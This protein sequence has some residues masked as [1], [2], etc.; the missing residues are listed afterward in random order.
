MSHLDEHRLIEKIQK[1]YSSKNRVAGISY[2]EKID[3]I[4]MDD[5]FQDY[6][7]RKDLNIICFNNNQLI[8][9]GMI[10]PAGPLREGLSSLKRA[11]IIIINGT[12]NKDFEEKVLRINKKIEIFYSEYKPESIEHLLNK[13]LIAISGI[14]N[15]QNFFQLLKN[16][17][18]KVSKKLV[19]PDHYI[20]SK[21]EL[22]SIVADAEKKN[23]DIIMSEKDYYKIKNFESKKINCLKVS[24]IINEQEKL[25]NKINEL[26]Y[27]NN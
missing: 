26:Y 25:L 1:F 14:G 8:G 2:N 13:E 9:N 18:L 20:F 4:I 10:L 7:I 24:L 21:N 12:K 3:S 5:G 23:Y 19:F 22:E 16:N 6:S 27:K 11:D 17:N 15:P